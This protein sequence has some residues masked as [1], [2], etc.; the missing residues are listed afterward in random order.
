[1]SQQPFTFRD[2]PGPRRDMVGYGRHAPRVRWPERRAGRDQHRHQLRGGLG[3]LPSRRR[4]PQRRPDRGHLQHGPGL[5]R[6]RRRIGVRVR[7]ARRH[8]AAGAAADG[9][10]AAGHVLCLRGRPRAEPR[11]RRL[12][13]GSRARTVLATAGAGR[14]SGRSPTPR[15]PSTSAA[16]SPRSRRPAASGRGGWYCRYGASVRT[17]ELLVRGGRFHL[18]FRCLQ[19]RP[20]LLRAGEGQARTSSSRIR[21]PTTTASSACCRAMAGH[22]ISLD[23]LKRGFDQLWREGETHPKMMSIGLH[24]RLI[25]QASRIDALREFIEYALGK[26]QVLFTRRI[27]IAELVERASSRVLSDDGCRGAGARRWTRIDEFNPDYRTPSPRSTATAQMRAAAAADAARRD[28]RLAR[29]AARHARSRVKDNIDTAG[30]RTACGSRC[31]PTA[32]RTPT[33][34]WSSDCARPGR[35]SSARPR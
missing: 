25:G 4:R 26:G 12:D 24:P 18:R 13:Q 14:K 9:I 19:R 35:S 28:G 1:M 8:L 30:M 22:P 7:L 23:N 33:R 17:R 31:S 32:F 27:D 29:P 20:S 21:S 11:G 3:I 2:V 16:P 6:P 34:R 15:R 5:S 10:Q